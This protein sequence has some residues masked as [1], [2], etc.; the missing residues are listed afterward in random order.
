MSL[1]VNDFEGVILVGFADASNSGVSSQ[2]CYI[3]GLVVFGQAK[4]DLSRTSSIGLFTSHQSTPP[5]Q[6]RYPQPA[7]PWMT[8]FQ[9]AILLSV[10]LEA[11]VQLAVLVDSKDPQGS[12]SSQRHPT[13]KLGDV[14]LIRFYYG[15][16]VDLFG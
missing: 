7:K 13:D 15:T 11:Q 10:I 1:P 4:K 2:L 14:I 3:V 12:L 6:Q 16:D 5:Q 8:L 9:L